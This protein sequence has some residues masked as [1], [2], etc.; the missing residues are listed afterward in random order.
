MI[1][2]LDTKLHARQRR[3]NM[4]IY[5]Y[6]QYMFTCKSQYLIMDHGS[7]FHSFRNSISNHPLTCPF[8][9]FLLKALSSLCF[10]S[11]DVFLGW[12]WFTM[13]V[14]IR[15][16][17]W[18][19]CIDS[20][21]IFTYMNSGSILFNILANTSPMDPLSSG[22]FLVFLAQRLWKTTTGWEYC[23]PKVPEITWTDVYTLQYLGCSTHSES[24]SCN[25][26]SAIAS[27]LEPKKPMG[28]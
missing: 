27:R 17:A 21:V 1:Y 19:W 3:N 26:K 22:K 24:L 4:Y 18:L 15:E 9:S 7:C 2:R 5:I 13:V 12:I 28:F 10:L 8:D 14:D 11:A 6:I 16:N 25:S 23:N 20:H